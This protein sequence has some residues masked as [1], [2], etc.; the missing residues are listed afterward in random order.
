[1]WA[2]GDIYVGYGVVICPQMGAYYAAW[3]RNNN[4]SSMNGSFFWGL[5]KRTPAAQWAG[6]R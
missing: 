5:H 2:F 1:M 3:W 4:S 6:R